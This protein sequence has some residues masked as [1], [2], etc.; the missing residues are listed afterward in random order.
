MIEGLATLQV[1]YDGHQSQ[2][3]HQCFLQ[4]NDSIVKNSIAN[5]YHCMCEAQAA[6]IVRIAKEKGKTNLANVSMKCLLTSRLKYLISH[7]LW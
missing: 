3:H 4:Q 6:G 5:S 2:W 7:K 1:V